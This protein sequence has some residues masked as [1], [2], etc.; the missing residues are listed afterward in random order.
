MKATPR[1][2]PGVTKQTLSLCSSASEIQCL[3]LIGGLNAHTLV[4]RC[5][6]SMDEVKPYVWGSGRD[7]TSFLK[8]DWA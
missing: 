6:P 7:K 4:V 1:I 3:Q 5:F 8:L 2:L